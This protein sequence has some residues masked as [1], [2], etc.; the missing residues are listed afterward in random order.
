MR[1]HTSR[2]H[3]CKRLQQ[4]RHS[5]I[6]AA[7]RPRELQ[8]PG[9]CGP[10][11]QRSC[12]CAAACSMRRVSLACSAWQR[13]PARGTPHSLRPSPCLA[14]RPAAPCE[15]CVNGCAAGVC[16]TGWGCCR[17]TSR[18]RRRTITAVAPPLPAAVKAAGGHVLD[19]GNGVRV[20]G[21]HI[22]SHKGPI[23]GALAAIAAWPA[24][25]RCHAAVPV[26]V[27]QPCLNRRRRRLCS[28]RC[29][30]AH[31]G[32]PG[33]AGGT[34][35]VLWRELRPPDAP[36]FRGHHQVGGRWRRDGSWQGT[37]GQGRAGDALRCMP[38]RKCCPRHCCPAA[39]PL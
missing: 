26:P 35:A 19:A 22:S 28:R 36:A 16:S 21:W 8:A 23:T 37:L 30:G 10:H 3:A 33:R 11:S 4:W 17:L 29:A 2:P 13:Q 9:S 14:P 6:A 20:G 27:P 24:A 39:S 15:M 38:Q 1:A 12:R 32:R 34:R 31:Q 5:E 18:R 25:R 7:A